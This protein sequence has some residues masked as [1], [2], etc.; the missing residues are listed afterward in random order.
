[1]VK[2][3][4][5][6][7]VREA[8][9]LS[10]KRCGTPAKRSYPLFQSETEIETEYRLRLHETYGG[11]LGCFSGETLVGVCC[12][13]FV[14]TERYLQ[15]V[16][17]YSDEGHPQSASEF[18]GYFE[19]NYPGYSINIGIP[20]ENAFAADALQRSGFDL[21]EDSHDMRL[22][23]DGFIT[24]RPEATVFRL[25]AEQYPEYAG[26]HDL[27]FPDIYWNAE[28]L[29]SD[30]ANWRIFVHRK[31]GTI[32][33]SAF[34]MLQNKM[35]EI[36]GLWTPDLQTA[37]VLLH[38]LI[39]ALAAENTEIGMMIFFVDGD[40]ALN[41]AVSR[42]CGFRCAGHYQLWTKTYNP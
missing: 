5:E 30:I 34:V 2:E 15:T 14:P 39:G 21:V 27:H 22:D 35:A 13:F 9:E 40:E 41:Q 36:F 4:T 8:A 18:L 6:E 23:R 29:F 42:E 32:D 24:G 7:R 33:G 25:E 10:W 3:L 26:F 20:F 11:L 19:S 16:A 38:G 17:F 28:R 37:R 12:F 31:N 1:M